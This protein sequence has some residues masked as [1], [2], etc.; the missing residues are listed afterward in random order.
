MILDP[1]LSMFLSKDL[2]I[3]LGTANTLVCARGEGIILSEPSVVAVYQGTNRVVD[4]NAVG[5]R[6][7]QMLGKTPGSIQAVRPMKNGVIAD[8]EITEQMLGYF[9]RKAHGRTHFI[10]PRVIVAVPS[11]ITVVE[12]RAVRESAERAGA[13]DVRLIKEPMAA[14]IGVGLPVN[15]PRGS[16]IVDIGG[17]TCEVAVISLRGIVSSTSLRC[18]G[19]EMNESIMKYLKDVYNL[20]IGEQTAERIKIEI[21]SAYPIEEE[22]VKEVRGSDTIAHLPRTVNVRSEEVREALKTP[23]DKIIRAIVTTLERTP[24]EL[25]ADLVESGVT[26][27]GGGALLR[28]IDRLI[29]RETGLPVRKADDPLT[30]VARGT[31]IVL[32]QIDTY[33]NVLENGHDAA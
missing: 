11:G 30:A 14:A 15:E 25:A 16:M 28:G 6:A 24:P 5:E 7:R 2:G 32:D 18:A 1:L 27:A 13:R 31:G 26:L 9:I 17:G 4:G 22:L 29:A 10:R 12:K 21:G 19:D 8:F 33:W 23:L 20:Q 3:D